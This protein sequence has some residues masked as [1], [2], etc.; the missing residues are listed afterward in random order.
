[1]STEDWYAKSL[2]QLCAKPEANEADLSGALIR[3][4]LANELG[5]GVAEID[6]ES[7]TV[8]GT[9]KRIRPDFVCGNPNTEFAYV[10]VEVK[11]TGTALDQ[12]KGRQGMSTSP[13]GQLRRYLKGHRRAGVGTWGVLTNGTDWLVVQRTD[14]DCPT[15]AACLEMNLPDGYLAPHNIAERLRDLQ[16]DGRAVG[17]AYGKDPDGLRRV[18]GF[19]SDGGTLLATALVD[20]DLPGSRA[21]GQF[22][23]LAAHASDP[24]ADAIL[25][26]LSS[27]P[28]HR[29]FH[30]EVA[31]WFAT[32]ADGLDERQRGNRLRHLI[33]VMFAWL[34]QVRGVLPDDALWLPTQKPR[35]NYAVHR[36]VVWLFTEVLAT[37]KGDRAEVS[38]EWQRSL[39]ESVPFLNGSLFT[40]LP[41]KERASQISNAEYIGPPWPSDDLESLRLDAIG[42]HRLRVR[43]GG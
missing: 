7:E 10:I 31:E 36:H 4:V 12:R 28:L 15:Y 9:G 39:V 2:A 13:A 21:L 14:E 24:S 25:D 34:L 26:A 27:A 32:G 42:P 16:L 19:H 5:F 3:P 22:A 43:I 40:K 11:R 33:R 30:E 37:P 20:P 17:V 8:S 6:A 35:G 38:N 29:Q 23:T 1:M 41:P 18:R